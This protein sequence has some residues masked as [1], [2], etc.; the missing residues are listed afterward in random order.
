M[1]WHNAQDPMPGD[2]R[3]CD[4]LE[5]VIV[6]RARDLGGFSVR[7]ALPSA[8]R[9]MVGPFIFLDQMGPAHFA[10]DTGIDVRPHPHIGLATVTY[11]FDGEIM[12]RDSLGS[13]Q[14][15]KPGALN[16]MTAGRGI[17]HSERT[18]P[19][20]RAR[21]AALSGI[22][23]WVAL[24]ED[25]E[26]TEPAFEHFGAHLL[27]SIIGEGKAIRIIAGSMFGASS[28]VKT[29]SPLFYAD[30]AMEAG[31]SFPL[32][33][34]EERALYIASGTVEIAGESFGEGNLLVFRPG[35]RITVKAVEDARFMALGGA[36]MEKPRFIWWNFVSSSKERIE[37]AKEDWKSG[38]FALVPGDDEFIPLPDFGG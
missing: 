36:P 20:L 27:P 24:P 21:G 3:S 10:P 38:R 8:Q 6:P 15:I 32:D 4:A 5:L 18:P 14:P 7:R 23:A 30:V 35:D 29:A 33:P 13:A 1:S 25:K 31:S 16:W 2:K 12:H 28:P 37:Q 11:L 19:E 9:R 26:E 34:D 22:Q 17:S